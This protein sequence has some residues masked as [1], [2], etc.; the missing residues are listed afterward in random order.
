MA[1]LL[2]SKFHTICTHVIYFDRFNH[3]EDKLLEK[4]CSTPQEEVIH[5]ELA[6]IQFLSALVN[7]PEEFLDAQNRLLYKRNIQQIFSSD[8]NSINDKGLPVSTDVYYQKNKV[9]GRRISAQ[10]PRILNIGSGAEQ[11]RKLPAIN[12]DVSLEGRP[13]VAA[14]AVTLPFTDNSFTIVRASHILEHIPQ[15][16]IVNT[17]LE[18]K[19]VLHEDGELHIAVPDAEVAF[20]EILNGHTSKGKVAFSLTESTAPLAQ[21]YGLGYDNIDTDTRWRHHIIFSYKLLEYF[22]RKVGFTRF[23]M[24]RNVDDLAYYSNVDD[25]S[26]NHYTLLVVAGKEKV[27][28]SVDEPL[29]NEAFLEKCRAFSEQVTE[30]VPASFIIPVHNEEKSL[31]H[32][33]TSLDA[34]TNE[35]NGQRE[36]IFVVNC[37]TD[38]SVRIIKEYIS[39]SKLKAKLVSSD[40]GIVVAF[41]KGISESS[42]NGFI[43][44]LDADTVLH[45]HALDL[46]QMFLVENP[47]ILATYS[48]PRPNDTITLYNAA[49]HIPSLRSR[50]L[51][52]HGRTSLHRF[53]PFQELLDERSLGELRAEDY[54]LSFYYAYFRGLGSIART[55][56]AV[57]YGKSVQTFHD[58]AMQLTRANAEIERVCHS[59]PPF[60]TIRSLLD[61][62]VFSSEYKQILDSAKGKVEEEKEGW[63]RLES[64]K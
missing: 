31:P 15:D 51:F 20:Q 13:E 7:S 40:K 10:L 27:P 18:W 1:L 62:E 23:E 54:F 48:E 9:V 34:T 28:H 39:T 63:T 16:K 2:I 56:H 22:L 58:L 45:P 3:I 29:S 37:C 12:I 5:D 49:E 14:D 33:L 36:F 46:M 64:T 35:I 32:F 41:R 57:V 59:F 38:E 6:R 60:R 52:F 42:L 4:E 25:D 24:R 8:E 53:N 30:V 19:R 26:Q 47:S 55:P 43:G 17:L 21:I 44:K 50:R 61:R 11:S